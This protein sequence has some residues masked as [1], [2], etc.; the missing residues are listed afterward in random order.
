MT[1]AIEYPGNCVRCNK[2]NDVGVGDVGLFELEILGDR[3]GEER[4]KRIPWKTSGTAQ[5]KAVG[6]ELQLQNAIMNLQWQS[7][8]S[9]I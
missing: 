4:R 3:E 2:S 8:S 1:R 6:I 9:S 7:A 5:K